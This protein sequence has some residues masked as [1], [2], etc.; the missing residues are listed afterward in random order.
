[1]TGVP[2]AW[3]EELAGGGSAR[4][5]TSQ[6]NSLEPAMTV[7]TAI[8]Q[9]I[10]LDTDEIMPAQTLDSSHQVDVSEAT[11]SQGHCPAA[12]W[13]Q[14]YGLA[15]SPRVPHMQ[16]Y[17]YYAS[18]P[19]RQVERRVRDRPRDTDSAL[20]G[21]LASSTFVSQSGSIPQT[22]SPGCLLRY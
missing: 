16:R 4:L 14:P 7:T 6:G 2:L 21:R 1:M 18:E 11:I 13:Q 5:P 17:C 19:S 15:A 10:T 9:E 8:D 3:L 20:C 12:G 22:Q